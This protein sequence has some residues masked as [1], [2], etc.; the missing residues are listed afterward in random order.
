MG[1]TVWYGFFTSFILFDDTQQWMMG[2]H[3][4]P[5]LVIIAKPHI[6]LFDPQYSF[7]RSRFPYPLF[8]G[9]HCMGRFLYPFF[10]LIIHNSGRGTNWRVYTTCPFPLVSPYWTLNFVFQK[11]IH[12]PLFYGTHC[13][14]YGTVSL[15]FHSFWTYNT[16]VEGAQSEGYTLHAPFGYELLIYL[17][18][19]CCC[20]RRHC[21]KILAV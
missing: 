6:S 18:M 8:Y 1:R 20:L 7:S 21:S 9:T 4:M 3:Y 12:Y 15:L 11:H 10:F 2:V 16:T 17:P 5:L 13:S 14:T 19:N